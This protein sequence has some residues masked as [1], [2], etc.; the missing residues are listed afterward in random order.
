MKKILIA[1][2]DQG[3]LDATRLILEYEGYK[4]QVVCDGDSVRNLNS[5]FPDLILLDIWLSGTHGG[6]IAKYLKSHY[7]TKKI[8]I[9]MFSANRDIEK[10]SKEAGADDYLIKPFDIDVLLKKIQKALFI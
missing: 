10:I 1:D 5:N 8:P 3:I 6:E 7:A 4:V 9:I 2:D